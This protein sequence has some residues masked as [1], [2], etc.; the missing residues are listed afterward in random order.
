[1]AVQWSTTSQQAVTHGAKILTYGGAGDG[2]TVLCATA[3][4]PVI[5][6][7]ESGLLSLS[8][9][10]LE[11]MFGVNN[12]AVTYDI[13]VMQ[14]TNIDQLTEAYMFFVRD[15]NA[16]YFATIC[17]DSLTEI[18]E[19]VL[20][21]AKKGV[22]DPRQAYGEL[23]ERIVW[24]IKAFRDMAGW[25]IYM[26]AKQEPMDTGHGVIKFGP[27]MPGKQ[28][29]VQIPYLFDEVFRLGIGQTQQGQK[30]RFIQTEGDMQFTAKDRSGVLDAMEPP[31]LTHII[32]K[33]LG[34]K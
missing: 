30:Y 9:R 7:A 34:A 4:K 21:N 13:P 6:S 20:A 23:T 22:K 1:M 28:L 14:V 12:P 33:L 18:G 25:N 26:S 29:P 2:K 32:N 3:P 5:I 16:R 24:L 10:N 15:P 19:V 8:R 17:L 27:S 31:D 11:R